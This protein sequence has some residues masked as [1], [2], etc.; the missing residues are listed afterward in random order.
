M[1][2]DRRQLFELFQDWDQ[3]GFSRI[4]HLLF[5][6][7]YQHVYRLIGC[8]EEAEDI[9]ADTLAKLWQR[10][11]DM[12]S[13]KHAS[14]FAYKTA[15]NAS[16]SYLRKK[17]RKT[18]HKGRHI[19]DL[20]AAGKMP[21]PDARTFSEIKLSEQIFN[22]VLEVIKNKFP[23]L[24]EQ[25][26]KVFRMLTEERSVKEIADAIGV[27]IPTVYTH[28]SA[29]FATLRKS[30]K[31]KGLDAYTLGFLLVLAIFITLV[32]LKFL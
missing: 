10:R 17:K 7:L 28:K 5:V 4:Y 21:D 19:K 22:E 3:P 13:L 18:S 8:K 16:I 32:Q 24:T 1:H 25:Q 29:A 2:N 26:Q 11:E 9:V 14:Y 27:G 15:T 20:S 31:E 23:Q 12:E 30:L 6:R